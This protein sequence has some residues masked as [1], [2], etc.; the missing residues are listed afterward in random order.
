MDVEIFDLLAHWLPAEIVYMID[1]KVVEMYR[2]DNGKRLAEIVAK[3]VIYGDY[4]VLRIR[5]PRVNVYMYTSGCRWNI[6]DVCKKLMFSGMFNWCNRKLA[7]PHIF[8]YARNH[9]RKSPAVCYCT[10]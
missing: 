9:Q 7:Y 5:D 8:G 2:R 6:C 10:I 3:S 1:D 4:H